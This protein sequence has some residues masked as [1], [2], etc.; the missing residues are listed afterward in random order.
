MKRQTKN[1][2]KKQADGTRT[3]CRL[4][5]S[6]KLHPILDLGKTPLADLFIND[7]FKKEKSYPLSISLCQNCFLVQLMFD[8]DDE[9][10]FGNHYAFYTGGSPSSLEY[11]K[12][13]AADVIKRYPKQARKFTLEIASNDGTLLNYFQEADCTI[14]GI[15]P[16]KNVTEYANK[17]NIKTITAFFDKKSAKKIN[18]EYGK[19][20]IIIANNVLAHTVDPLNFLEGAKKLLADDGVFIFECQYF[21]YLLFNNQF[22]NVYHEHR[23]FFSLLP[24][25]YALDKIGLKIIDVQEHDTQGGSIR[26]FTAHKNHPITQTD[27]AKEM[28]SNEIAFGL[29]KIETYSGFAGRVNYIKIQ[30]VNLLKELKKQGKTIAGYGASAKS[31]TLLNYCG[32]TTN[33]LD[34]IADKTPYKIGLYTPGTHIP[35]IDKEKAARLLSFTCMELRFRHSPKRIRIQKKRRQIYYSHPYPTDSMKNIIV[36]GGLGFIGF[37]LVTYLLEENKGNVII[38]DRTPEELYDSEVKKLIKKSGKKLRIIC[39]DLTTSDELPEADEIYHLAGGVGSKGIHAQSDIVSHSVI[40]L[41]NLLSAYANKKVRFLF[42]SSTEIAGDYPQKLPLKENCKIGWSDPLNPRWQYSIAKFICENIIISKSKYLDFNIAR[43]GNTYGERMKQNYVIKSFIT[44][45]IN[46]ENP[47][48]IEHPYDTRAFTYIADIVEGLVAIMES[49]IIKEII[50]L[51]SSDEISI[52]N[53]AKKLLNISGNTIELKIKTGK[54]EP[55]RRSVDT[56]KAKKMLNWYPK[57]SLDEGL[58]RTY[59]YYK[60]NTNFI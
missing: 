60:M 25:K 32:I 56:Q 21:P 11:F 42:I 15:D 59:K 49:Q 55:E 22:D 7:N 19:A 57:I 47:F 20:E 4:C 31:N 37:H 30:L 5:K 51:G 50:N 34:Y 44:R 24:L 52:E 29:K 10:L 53:L 9:L 54:N 12:G 45:L 28:L 27:K 17:H 1:R 43:L 46:K 3:F 40:P 2:I 36:T 33:Y 39:D 23:S 13:Y 38:I 26:V 58:R 8:V 48:I 41:E 14:L 18:D 35:V 6:K 16:A